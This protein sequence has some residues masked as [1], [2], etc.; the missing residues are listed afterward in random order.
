[1]IISESFYLETYGIIEREYRE[2]LLMVS[3]DYT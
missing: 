1:M 2:Y 3:L